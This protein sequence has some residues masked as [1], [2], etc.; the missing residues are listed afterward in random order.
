MSTCWKPK[1]SFPTP[2]DEDEDEQAVRGA[3]GEQVHGDR[4]R[5][6][7]DRAEGDREQDEAE[8][9]HED[10]DDRE[11]RVHDVVVVDVLGGRAA[12]ERLGV[13]AGE[14]RGNHLGAELAYGRDR[15]AARPSP[16]P[17]A[18]SG[19]RACRRG[20]SPVAARRR[21]RARPSPAWSRSTAARTSGEVESPSTTTR[22]GSVVWPGNS[23]F[24]RRKPCFDSKRSGSVLIPA[25]PLSSESTGMAAAR[26]SADR[27]DEAR[28]PAA[29]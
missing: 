24:R 26:R 16:R 6:D 14:C 11:P 17:P 21:S 4:G 2:F 18:P 13:R 10:E 27:R 23:R 15:R 7:D 12:H 22:T 25:V 8:A 20:S 19:R 28:R 29:A 3:D 1:S 9:E 5:R